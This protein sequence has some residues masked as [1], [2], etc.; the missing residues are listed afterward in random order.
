MG[1][2]VKNLS[3]PSKHPLRASRL[4]RRA[5]TIFEVTLAFALLAIVL[6][7]S[8]QMARVVSDHRRANE[9]KD[10]AL[11]AAQAISEQV[12]NIPWDE[13]TDDTASQIAIPGQLA[14]E[15]TNAKCKISLTDES[16]PTAKRVLVQISW[17]SNGQVPTAQ[18]TSWIYPE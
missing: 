10:V 2:Q 16:N 13:L 3:A 1:S 6:A 11:Q 18:L 8:V 12:G 9:H 17:N 7:A 14:S 4:R 5:L 15:L